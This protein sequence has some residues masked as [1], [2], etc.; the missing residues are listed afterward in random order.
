M[1]LD[2]PSC[3]ALCSIWAVVR[4]T[5]SLK[6]QVSA[7]ASSDSVVSEKHSEE[8]EGPSGLQ[9][10]HEGVYLS[11]FVRD[12][13]ARAQEQNGKHPFSRNRERPS[14]GKKKKRIP[15]EGSWEEPMKRGEHQTTPPP[16]KRFIGEVDS[17]TFLHSEIEDSPVLNT[18]Q[19]ERKVGSKKPFSS[20]SP[21][22][23]ARPNII[24][25]ITDDQDVE[26]GSMNFM[27][28]TLRLL[29]DEGATFSNAYVSTPMCCPSRSSLLTGLYVHNHGVYTNNENCSSAEWRRD[30]EPRSFAPYLAQ[31]GYRTGQFY[32]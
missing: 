26:L 7:P 19:T 23:P 14:R 27:P 25:L 29:K 21:K 10:L 2:L 1:R 11:S 12:E 24:L 28:K 8:E 20:R 9:H 15:M 22:K 18:E 3:V 4:C 31:A 5:H 17:S 32:S 13:E 30:H 6:G 16:K